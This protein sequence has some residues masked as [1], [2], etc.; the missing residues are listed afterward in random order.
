MTLLLDRRL[1]AL[2]AIVREGSFDQGAQSINIST[3][4][5]SQRIKSLE[6]LM[7]GM[8]ISRNSPCKVNE[9]GQKLLELTTQFYIL[10]QEAFPELID[11][12]FLKTQLLPIKIATDPDSL[13]TWLP[14]VIETIYSEMP[15]PIEFIH[16]A[17][18]DNSNL[19]GIWAIISPHTVGILAGR[20]YLLG[21]LNCTAVAA[22]GFIERYFPIG[23]TTTA[24]TNATVLSQNPNDHLLSQW[25][26][27]LSL[28]TSSLRMQAIPC[29]YGQIRACKN[30]FGWC[31]KPL[32]IL[33]E[34]LQDGSL[35]E[36]FPGNRLSVPIYW[37]PR[38]SKD[39]LMRKLTNMIISQAKT[40]LDP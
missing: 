3:S 15:C 39:V 37:S 25:V 2:M 19:K 33:Q 1:N 27:H 40:I 35:V 6:K 8:L 24:L 28:E 34:F 9:M 12:S 14:Y 13:S 31:V 11:Y 4:A 30:G 16:S 7:G 26:S 22:P 23:I 5:I 10:E 18:I 20:S 29:T 17:H 38:K 32:C 21:K 36:L